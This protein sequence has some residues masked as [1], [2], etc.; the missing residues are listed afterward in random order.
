M[1][2]FLGK[3]NF[4]AAISALYNLCSCVQFV[5]VVAY[6]L[7]LCWDITDLVL[8]FMFQLAC[9]FCYINWLLNVYFL[10][11]LFDLYIYLLYLWNFF[12][13][14]LKGLIDICINK[15]QFYHYIQDYYCTFTIVNSLSVFL[16]KYGLP[17]IF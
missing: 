1:W 7:G 9:F 10:Y 11:K 2:F 17:K 3:I 13:I 8:S 16:C 5:F 12:C 6:C 4:N 15:I 14:L